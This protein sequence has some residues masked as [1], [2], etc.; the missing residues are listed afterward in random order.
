[1]MNKVRKA[2]SGENGVVRMELLTMESEGE[3]GRRR[4]RGG[5]GEGEERRGKEIMHSQRCTHLEHR[6][7]YTVTHTQ[8]K[9]NRDTHK[10]IHIYRESTLT[11]STVTKCLRAFS[12]Y[13]PTLRSTAS[14]SSM[15]L[16]TSR[17]RAAKW[18]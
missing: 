17:F 5:E 13:V 6:E 16:S 12:R 4:E 11:W 9:K 2:W 1:M 3:E 14:R 10:R 18:R 7:V 15:S 8:T